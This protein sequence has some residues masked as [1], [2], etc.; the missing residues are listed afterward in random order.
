MSSTEPLPR[1][2]RPLQT[3]D[4]LRLQLQQLDTSGQ[5]LEAEK[6]RL[7]DQLSSVRDQIAA[8]DQ[9]IRLIMNDLD[10]QLFLERR[11]DR[12]PAFQASIISNDN[13]IEGLWMQMH[14]NSGL[15]DAL[16]N[17]VNEQGTVADNNLVGQ[18]LM[19]ELTGNTFQLIHSVAVRVVEYDPNNVQQSLGA[20][21]NAQHAVT[22]SN[23]DP[24]LIGTMDPIHH[25]VARMPSVIPLLSPSVKSETDSVRSPLVGPNAMVN[26][27][28]S[29]VMSPPP[30][31]NAIST[32][33]STNLLESSTGSLAT[34]DELGAMGQGTG[35]S[36]GM[37]RLENRFPGFLDYLRSS[38]NMTG[39]RTK[40]TPTATKRPVE[41][42]SSPSPS[43][44][45]TRVTKKAKLDKEPGKSSI[46]TF[47][48]N[49]LLQTIL[50]N[51]PVITF[52]FTN[53]IKHLESLH[54]QGKPITPVIRCSRC[55]EV[56][57][58]SRVLN[59][60]HLYCHRCIVKLRNEAQK[61]DPKIGFRAFCVQNGCDE[62]VSG[63]TAVVEGDVV[64]L[65]NW[66]DKQPAGV[67][68][69]AAR[70]HV[71]NDA[72]AK[73]PD[74]EDIKAKKE[75][76]QTQLNAMRL[77][78]GSDGPCDLLEVT[79]LAKKPY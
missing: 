48:P 50:T 52:T 17:I 77:S 68:M 63:K 2:H 62:V 16:T 13:I 3:P 66:Y 12:Q 21:N 10:K 41:A 34:T 25:Q 35:A 40:T 8:N 18:A 29:N 58:D 75:S 30:V 78:G 65:L 53:F 43:P 1:P 49:A 33:H 19:T 71:L 11:A 31:P 61:G 15:K 6:A 32:F 55:Q 42:A 44:V 38:E 20:A 28:M 27:T 79:K 74:D 26:L 14:Q 23:I 24:A 22:Q 56:R 70:L 60:M 76:V 72:L 36:Q 45:T 39:G 7:E 9:S 59:C 57:R 5:A 4:S 54:Q 37:S 47:H 73:R 69:G 67:T 46:S 64:D 51:I